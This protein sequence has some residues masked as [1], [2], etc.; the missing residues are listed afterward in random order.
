MAL[1][2]K[3][4]ACSSLLTVHTKL[5]FVINITALF[6]IHNTPCF[7]STC[8]CTYMLNAKLKINFND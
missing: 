1:E 3:K 7:T 8:T 4:V 2:A 6:K 5:Y